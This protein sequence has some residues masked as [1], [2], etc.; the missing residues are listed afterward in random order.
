MVAALN[1]FAISRSELKVTVERNCIC[2][3][4][5]SECSSQSKP[6][7]ICCLSP[8]KRSW[9]KRSGGAQ[10][11]FACPI[12]TTAS[13]NAAWVQ[14]SWRF[15]SS[16]PFIR[17]PNP[18]FSTLPLRRVPTVSPATC[19]TPGTSV[20]QHYWQGGI[21]QHSITNVAKDEKLQEQRWEL[22]WG[23]WS[24]LP[25]FLSLLSGP[26]RLFCW[27]HPEPEPSGNEWCRPSSGGVQKQYDLGLSSKQ[28]LQ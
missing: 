24:L 1:L 18:E 28:A 10:A 15:L 27:L 22:K 12:P 19:A 3:T 21:M 14:G 6:V 16:Q 9:E 7:Q 4:V 8:E 17:W 20:T 26:E 25:L 2:R 23:W 5:V 13:A 11:V